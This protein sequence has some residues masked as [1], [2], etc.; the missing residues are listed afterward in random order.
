MSEQRP[1]RAHQNLFNNRRIV[2]D[3]TIAHDII[4]A[5]SVASI[6]ESSPEVHLFIEM[7]PDALDGNVHPTKAEVRVRDQSTVHEAVRRGLM[8]ALGQGGGPRLQR[9]PEDRVDRPVPPPS[10]G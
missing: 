4:D 8:D 1:T 10:P 5:Y 9:R 2:K 3:R 7:P 6:K